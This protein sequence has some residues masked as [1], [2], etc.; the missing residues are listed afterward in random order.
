MERDECACRWEELRE[1]S[2]FNPDEGSKHVVLCYHPEGK[3]FCDYR[4]IGGD[5][6]VRD[7]PFFEYAVPLHEVEIRQQLKMVEDDLPP[8]KEM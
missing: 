1:N 3:G 5:Y 4:E 7:C 2:E 8:A 6:P